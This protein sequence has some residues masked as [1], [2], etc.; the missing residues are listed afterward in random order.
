MLKR[1]YLPEKLTVV[2]NI[3]KVL[4]FKVRYNA[5]KKKCASIKKMCFLTE[6]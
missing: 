4:K 2:Y 1:Y 5:L 3:L 6:S